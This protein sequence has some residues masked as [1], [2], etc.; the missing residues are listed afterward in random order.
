[1]TL[2]SMILFF[3]FSQNNLK[4]VKVHKSQGEAE[5]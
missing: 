3:P 1:M 2:K 4:S 5:E